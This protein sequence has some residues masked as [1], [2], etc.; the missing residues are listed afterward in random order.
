MNLLS[1][2]MF[3]D[4]SSYFLLACRAFFFL[5]LLWIVMILKVLVCKI[6]TA[7][8]T[9]ESKRHFAVQMDWLFIITNNCVQRF[10]CTHLFV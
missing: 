7:L 8:V 5:T 1:F 2:N 3:K 6:V 4:F 10:A 9:I